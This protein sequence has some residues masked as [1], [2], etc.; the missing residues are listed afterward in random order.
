MRLE[1]QFSV[2][3]PPEAV[4]AA[5]I[6]PE[7]V[8]PCMPG[9]TLTEVDGAE[10]SGGVKVKVGP[11]SLLYKGSGQFLETDEQ[12]RR[13][14]IKAA[15]KDSR[16][17][18]TASATVTVTLAEEDGAT[19]GTVVTDLTITGKPAQ[20][21]RGMIVEVGGKI[22]DTF[23]ACLADKLN[24][25]GEAVASE[26]AA[27]TA[28]DAAATDAAPATDAV[29]AD[30]AAPPAKRRTRAKVTEPPPESAAASDGDASDGADEPPPP[31]QPK[32]AT[33][34]RTTTTSKATTRSKT[35][36]V[37]ANDD[38][39]PA[40]APAPASVNGV[41]PAQQEEPAAPRLQLVEEP[42][43]RKVVA[44][45]E[46]EAIDLLDYAGP[47]IAKRL[48]PAVLGLI[49]LILVIR[50]LRRH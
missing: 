46:T 14:V 41:A 36:S 45:A 9:A 39:A 16:G 6:D 40:P 35:T 49:V 20:F 2:P 48:I 7:R 28:T 5:V 34:R 18:G 12:A 1:H 11:V 37:A 43:A 4:W 15:G 8:A 42:P 21:G 19:L 3:A 30:A 25:E 29:V 50:R 26:T 47:S 23:A 32:P 44:P 24:T 10:F 33:R 38:T 22:L 13:V 27:A 17:N 31:V